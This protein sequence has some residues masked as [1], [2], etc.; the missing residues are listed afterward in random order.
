[1]SVVFGAAAE[2][3]SPIESNEALIMKETMVAE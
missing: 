3:R 1:M 2:L